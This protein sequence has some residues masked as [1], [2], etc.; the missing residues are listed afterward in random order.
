MLINQ[1]A[2]ALRIIAFI[3]LFGWMLYLGV[4][5]NAQSKAV[6]VDAKVQAPL[7]VMD[8]ISD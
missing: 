6:K 3:N 7:L 2:S 5:I 4:V 1:I 8:G